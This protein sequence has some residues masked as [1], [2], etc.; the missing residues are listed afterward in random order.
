MDKKR[1]YNFQTMDLQKSEHVNIFIQKMARKYFIVYAIKIHRPQCNALG[2]K[3]I[4]KERRE[5]ILRKCLN[6]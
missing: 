3:N 5:R 2:E 6:C 1:F 4:V